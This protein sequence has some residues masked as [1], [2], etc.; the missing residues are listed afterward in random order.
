[1]AST[2]TDPSGNTYTP[3][4]VNVLT[5][6][7]TPKTVVHDVINPA[8]GALITNIGPGVLAGN[9]TAVFADASDADAFAQAVVYGVQFD[10]VTHFLNTQVIIATGEIAVTQ[11]P[12]TL[13]AWTVAFPWAVLT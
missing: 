4:V 1:M 5:W 3:V 7:Y 6:G 8:Y 13:V 12:Q 11:D 2:F 9:L 10:D